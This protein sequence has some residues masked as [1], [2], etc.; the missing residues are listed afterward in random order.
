MRQQPCSRHLL[1]AVLLFFG[2]VSCPAEET[3]TLAEL[4][5]DFGVSEETNT[6]LHATERDTKGFNGRT[7][8]LPGPN[9]AQSA[10]I[11]RLWQALAK[12]KYIETRIK[13]PKEPSTFIVLNTGKSSKMPPVE[14]IWID[15]DGFLH[16]LPNHSKRPREFMVFSGP[17]V[18]AWAA[19]NMKTYGQIR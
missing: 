5:A 3:R 14:E 17:E 16:F 19:E 11:P 7:F 1:F 4:C 15:A 2:I 9:P 12:T 8:F 6:M 10:E 18:V 13:E